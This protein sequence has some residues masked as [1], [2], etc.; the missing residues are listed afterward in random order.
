MGRIRKAIE[1]SVAMGSAR[2]VGYEEWTGQMLEKELSLDQI[3]T[4]LHSYL[5]DCV[6]V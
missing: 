1:K 4:Y 5:S 3:K 2:S 6:H